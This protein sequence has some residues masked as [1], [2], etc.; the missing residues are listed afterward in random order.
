MCP[1][2]RRGRYRIWWA[3]MC[4][5]TPGTTPGTAV[6]PTTAGLG[7][8]ARE[9]CGEDVDKLKRDIACDI[10]F[11]VAAVTRRRC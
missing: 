2:V 4:R 11:Q 5:A 9:G 6:G 7:D 8:R 3:R 1:Q 10:T